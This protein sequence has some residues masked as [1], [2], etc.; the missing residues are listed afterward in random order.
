[1]RFL[2]SGDSVTPAKIDALEVLSRKARSEIERLCSAN[3]PD[4][5]PSDDGCNEVL[6][7]GGGQAALALLLKLKIEGVRSCVAVDENLPGFAG[8]WRKSARMKWL[9]TPKQ[10]LGPAG[11]IG[12]L[13]VQAWY[14]ARFSSDAWARMEYLEREEWAEYLEWFR[15]VTNA[16]IVWNTKVTCLRPQGEVFQVESSGDGG[17]HT[18]Q[19]RRVV[20]ADGI[21]A[22]GTWQVPEL[23]RTSLPSTYFSLSTDDI[24]FS[25]FQGKRVAIL[26]AGA[27]AFDNALVCARHGASQV[28]ILSRRERL[29]SVNPH[30]W[31]GF[32]LFLR[33]FSHLENADK[34]RFA[35][36]IFAM[37]QLPPKHTFD[38]A[39]EH[40]AIFVRTR[41]QLQALK[42]CDDAISL[43]L[44]GEHLMVDHL[45]VAAG[46]KVDLAARPELGLIEPLIKR[47]GDLPDVSPQDQLEREL[48]AYPF[49]GSGFQFLPRRQEDEFVERIFCFNYGAFLSQGLSGASITGLKYGVD[50]IVSEISRQ[51]FR[52]RTEFYYR[53]LENYHEEEFHSQE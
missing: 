37:G 42:L 3:R 19:A 28:T 11:L 52:E 47:W 35:K 31:L 51:I 40:P 26:G 2:A 53:N 41:S 7:I 18:L 15:Q 10:N 45:V 30:K 12:A 29:V 24:D 1:M 48:A 8:P 25:K 44:S 34:W 46:F 49:L 17:Q 43:D 13:S 20:L 33:S 9:R 21:A 23:V 4:P 39:M 14:E 36:K 5:Y 6:I 32:N 50:K 22:S 27:G 38:A 16:N